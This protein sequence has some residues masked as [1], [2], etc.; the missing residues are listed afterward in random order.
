MNCETVSG[1][2]KTLSEDCGEGRVENG[3]TN[4]SVYTQRLRT[5]TGEGTDK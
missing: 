3:K 4:E 2:N 5:E 1:L